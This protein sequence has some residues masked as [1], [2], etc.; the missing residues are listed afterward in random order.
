MKLYHHGNIIYHLF[1]PWNCHFWAPTNQPSTL[2]ARWTPTSAARKWCI[3]AIGQWCLEK[4]MGCFKYAPGLDTCDTASKFYSWLFSGD[5]WDRFLCFL[6]REPLCLTF[7]DTT[8]DSNIVAEQQR[9]YFFLDLG[10]E[11]SRN[12]TVRGVAMF[13]L[14]RLIRNITL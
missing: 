8:G 10:D 12:R 9:F 7:Q 6:R 1:P 4:C 13:L 14:L 5:L 11:K 3:P 2:S